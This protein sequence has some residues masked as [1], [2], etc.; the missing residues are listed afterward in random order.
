MNSRNLFQRKFIWLLTVQ[1]QICNHL[2]APCCA[3]P[4][5]S[6]IIILTLIHKLYLTL[7]TIWPSRIY[8]DSDIEPLSRIIHSFLWCHQRQ[9]HNTPPRSVVGNTIKCKACGVLIFTTFIF[10]TMISTFI[11]FAFG[12]LSS[13]TW[14]YITYLLWI[15]STQITKKTCFWSTSESWSVVSANT[16]L[17]YISLSSG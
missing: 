13:S 1:T 2:W 3:L 4:A 10:L 14:H 7:F 16:L 12:G 15:P 5:P 8:V 11:F 6:Y 9:T 17:C